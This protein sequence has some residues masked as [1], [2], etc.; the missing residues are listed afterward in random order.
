MSKVLPRHV[1]EN[2]RAAGVAL[3]DLGT[4]ACLKYAI[5]VPAH[6]W[7]LT[8]AIWLR[9]APS[10]QMCAPAWGHAFASMV[11]REATTR[12]VAAQRHIRFMTTQGDGH[13]LVKPWCFPADSPI[14]QELVAWAE[15]E[16]IETGLPFATRDAFTHQLH[17]KILDWGLIGAVAHPMRFAPFSLDSGSSSLRAGHDPWLPDLE[18]L[19]GN[20]VYCINAVW[21]IFEECDVEAGALSRAA[22]GSL[23]GQV[24]RECQV[25]MRRVEKQTQLAAVDGGIVKRRCMC[26]TTPPPQA[27]ATL[28]W[29]ELPPHA[30]ISLGTTLP[31]H[32][33]PLAR[34]WHL[35]REIGQGSFG[36]VY[37]GAEGSGAQAAIKVA[38]DATGT[39]NVANL[40]QAS[41]S[42]GSGH[43]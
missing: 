42:E 17:S 19:T 29:P 10:V 33:T 23:W 36:T 15:V 12:D 39:H 38:V 40:K 21:S 22:L 35:L 7:I 41:C 32:E 5:T 43:G 30:Q 18:E 8:D 28:P 4:Y 24:Q 26:K 31:F 25:R 34:R 3:A 11:G 6:W 16:C 1:F 14:L 2:L 9:K 20:K 37:L 13:E 27:G